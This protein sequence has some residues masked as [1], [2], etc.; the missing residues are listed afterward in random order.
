MAVL[1]NATQGLSRCHCSGLVWV[2]AEVVV[3]AV[4]IAEVGGLHESKPDE[5]HG[6]WDPYWYCRIGK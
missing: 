6:V 4:V 5:D 2:A 1:L 3:V